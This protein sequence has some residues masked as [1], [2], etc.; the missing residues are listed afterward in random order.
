MKLKKR[1]VTTTA[2]AKILKAT[3]Q[4]SLLFDDG[5]LAMDFAEL[6][7]IWYFGQH[8]RDTFFEAY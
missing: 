4:T 8:G 5:T 1:C 7:A 6:D 2:F 3:G